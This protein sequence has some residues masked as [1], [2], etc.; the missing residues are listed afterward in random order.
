MNIN[1]TLDGAPSRVSEI[2]I[3]ED[4]MERVP[5]GLQAA[6]AG[7]SAYW[8]WDEAVWSLWGRKVLI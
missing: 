8:I 6:L 4:V 1:I 7:R 5:A 3:G 2:F